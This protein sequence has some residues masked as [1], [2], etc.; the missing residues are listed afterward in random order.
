[1]SDQQWPVCVTPRV[2]SILNEF[3]Y[4]QIF[5]PHTIFE[6]RICFYLKIGYPQIPSKVKTMMIQC[7]VWD[8]FHGLNSQFPPILWYQIHAIYGKVDTEV[9]ATEKFKKH[10]LRVRGKKKTWKLGRLAWDGSFQAGQRWIRE[11]NKRKKKNIH[12]NKKDKNKQEWE[13]GRRT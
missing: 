6:L 1:M 11:V 13:G 7:P 4:W 5:W 2:L 3:G 12:N 10:C 8:E 9:L